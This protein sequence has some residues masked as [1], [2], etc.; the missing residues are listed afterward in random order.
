MAPYNVVI[1]DRARHLLGRQIIFLARVSPSAARRAKD[2][3]LKAIRSLSRN[4]ARF[5]FLEAEH[6]PPNK[7]HKMFV[8]NWYL[9]LYQIRD[10][11]VYVDY[12]LDCRQDY[13]WLVK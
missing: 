11:N 5:P 1:S 7:Y 9:V 6:L 10:R 8:E 3:I 2:E 12:V 13:G 4:P